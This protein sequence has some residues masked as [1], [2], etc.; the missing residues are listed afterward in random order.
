MEEFIFVLL[1]GFIILIIPSFINYIFK[2]IILKKI[3]KERI[4]K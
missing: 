2:I 4:K 1:T 3:E